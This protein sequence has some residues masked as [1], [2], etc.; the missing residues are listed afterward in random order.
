[1]FAWRLRGIILVV[2]ATSLFV[3][4]HKVR[5]ENG[6]KK[7]LR[8]A[9]S[10]EKSDLHKSKVNFEVCF[11]VEGVTYYCPGDDRCCSPG[12]PESKCC[13]AD[14]PLCLPEEDPEFCC[15]E[16]YPKLCGEYCCTASSFC[17]N[18]ENCCLDERE[19]CGEQCCEAEE[20]C[21]GGNC[22]EA[23]LFCCNEESCCQDEAACCGKNCCTGENSCCKENATETCCNKN[24]MG[25]CDG[26]GCVSPCQ[27]QFDAIGCQLSRFS[28][29]EE[30]LLAE[31]LTLPENIYRILRP[32]ENPEGIVAKNP[33]AQKTVLSHVN[34]GSRPQYASQFISTSAS[35]DVAKYYM[36]KGKE[37]GLTGLRICQFEVDKLPQSCQIVDLTTEENRDK[38]LGN[39]VCKNFAKASAEVLL[40]CSL[41]A[42]CTVFDPPPIGKRNFEEL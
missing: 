15:P 21:C 17:C 42:S 30:E 40:Q 34:C 29:E 18:E 19:C 26:Y 10:P 24:T 1:M 20:K 3:S 32:D 25:C 23:G 35:L 6:C 16:G 41:P 38:Y 11:E 14:H 13:P 5:R 39:A 31:P 7:A 36:E 2:L 12:N 9:A 33:A 37:K 27:S 28:L 4:G 8:K 22:C